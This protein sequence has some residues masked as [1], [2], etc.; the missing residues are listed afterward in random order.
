MSLRISPTRSRIGRTVVP[1]LAPLLAALCL[2]PTRAVA[3]GGAL[4]AKGAATAAPTTTQ[5][6]RATSASPLTLATRRTITGRV[7]RE[8]G[9][10]VANATFY[11]Q[12]LNQSPPVTVAT[13]TTGADGTYTI[14]LE[15]GRWRVIATSPDYDFVPDH[16][17]Y[18]VGF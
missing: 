4:P 16:R 10:P 12:D 14:T 18:Q 11:I 13:V 5:Q 2:V 7:A 9:T 15:W 6:L 1:L 8:D 17:D 3:A